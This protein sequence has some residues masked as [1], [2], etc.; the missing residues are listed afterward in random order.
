M[1]RRIVERLTEAF[2]LVVKMAGLN[3]GY[4]LLRG[5]FEHFEGKFHTDDTLPTLST[6][7]TCCYA[8]QT[9]LGL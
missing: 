2:A 7:A 8:E 5:R 6:R 9:N 4:R 3:D 1:N